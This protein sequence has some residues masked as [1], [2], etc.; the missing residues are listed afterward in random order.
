MIEKFSKLKKKVLITTF[1]NRSLDNILER[2]VE[3]KRV[4]KDGI[5]R[6]GSQ[7]SC[8]PLLKEFT[9]KA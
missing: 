5:I 8:S 6:E 2:L 9:S 7:Y 1:T 3:S 4:E